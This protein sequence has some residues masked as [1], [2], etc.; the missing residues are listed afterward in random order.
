MTKS[1]ENSADQFW[2]AESEAK[3]A[4]VSNHLEFLKEVG[5]NFDTINFEGTDR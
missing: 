3:G 5:A 1:R 4:G 2:V